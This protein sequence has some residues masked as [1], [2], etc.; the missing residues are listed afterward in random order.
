MFVHRELTSHTTKQGQTKQGQCK[1]QSNMPTV[2]E[3]LEF[4]KPQETS[5]ETLSEMKSNMY[6]KV[7]YSIVSI[8]SA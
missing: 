6:E 4:C 3:M 8:M 2:P 5:T 1:K 7:V